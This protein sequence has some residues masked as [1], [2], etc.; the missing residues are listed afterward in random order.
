MQTKK[1]DEL[2]IGNVFSIPKS[3]EE[4]HPPN[5]K[6]EKYRVIEEAAPKGSSVSVIVTRLSDGH[7]L[8]IQMNKYARVFVT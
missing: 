7:I 8:E 5:Y 3:E 1:P 4:T 6:T 2:K